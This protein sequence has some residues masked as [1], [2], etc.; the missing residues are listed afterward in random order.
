MM[1]VIMLMRMLIM[2]IMVI[3]VTYDAFS[4][5]P[6]SRHL[7][8]RV[9]FCGRGVELDAHGAQRAQFF[10][11]VVWPGNMPKCNSIRMI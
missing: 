2:M 7:C 9:G 1:M 3:M 11:G 6:G 5:P 10:L 4:R 8:L